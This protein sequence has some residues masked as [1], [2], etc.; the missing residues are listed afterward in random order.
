[1]K[2]AKKVPENWK[3]TLHKGKY[4]NPSNVNLASVCEYVKKKKKKR[5]L[6]TQLVQFT[7]QQIYLKKQQTVENYLSVYVSTKY[8]PM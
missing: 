4:L 3:Q 7:N 2:K 5:N 1:M 8:F 6:L